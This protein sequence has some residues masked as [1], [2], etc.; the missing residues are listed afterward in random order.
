[1]KYINLFENFTDYEKYLN[2]F[3]LL[4]SKN[5]KD[6]NNIL[7]CKMLNIDDRFIHFEEYEY[8]DFEKAYQVISRCLH[9]RDFNKYYQ[10]L[11]T[12]DTFK[13]M[14]KEFN[15]VKNTNKYNL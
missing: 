7:M 8:D 1:M 10:I 15:L 9:I 4:I 11:N 6:F 2:K 13:Q 5:H 3:F 14:K 12:F